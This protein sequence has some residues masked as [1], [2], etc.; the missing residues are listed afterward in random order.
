M[1][2]NETTEMAAILHRVQ[3]WP[4]GMRLSLAR[5][6]LQGLEQSTGERERQAPRGRSAAEVMATLETNKPAA[7]DATVKKWLDED[8]MEKYGQ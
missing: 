6:I 8:R 2:N 1:N 3:S 5:Q 4:Q 7:D